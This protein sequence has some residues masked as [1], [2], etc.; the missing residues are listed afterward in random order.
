MARV[1]VLDGHSAAALAFTR[2]LGKRGH[3]VAVGYAGGIFAAAMRS[4]YCREVFEY[5]DSTK[6]VTGFVRAILEF[7][8]SRNIELLIPITDWTTTPVS[9]QRDEIERYCRIA[10]PCP[11][12]LEL[13]SDKYR[14]IELAASFEVPVPETWLIRRAED[15]DELP[16]LPYPVVVKDRESARWI[17]NGAVFGSVSYAYSREDLGL[18][19]E[20]RLAAAG[21]VL[22]QRFA[23]GKGIGFSCFAHA[24]EIYL[25]FQ[26][27]RLRETDPRGSASS[28]RRSVPVDAQVLEFSRRLMR[29]AGFEGLA[30]VEFKQDRDQ[31]TLMEINGRPWGSIQLPIS[32]GIDYPNY[33]VDWYLA[34]RLPPAA[35][36]YRKIVCRRLVG[37]LNHLDSLRRGKPPEWPTPYPNFW[38]SL[39]K[40]AVPWYPGVRYDDLWLSDPR[41]GLAGLAHWFGVRLNRRGKRKAPSSSGK[42]KRRGIVHCHTTYSYD[43]KLELAEL[44]DLLRREG[45][46]FVALTEHTQGLTAERYRELVDHCRAESDGRFLA[47]PGIEFRSDGMEIAGIGL[48]EWIEESEPK[49]TAAAIASAGG[50]SIW[51]HPFKDGAWSGAFPDCDAVELLNGKVNGTLAPDFRL[52]KAYC[53]QRRQGRSFHAIF[54]LDFHNLR[55]PRQVW[56]ECE[57]EELSQPALLEALREGKFV[58][59]VAH[60]SMTSSGE[61]HKLD[62]CKM[63]ILRWAFLA[64]AAILR[65]TPTGLR[66][67]LLSLSRPLVRILKRNH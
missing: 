41:P 46:D 16:E 60:G 45:F 26:W 42:R 27:V 67:S 17:G 58:S 65:S 1:L 50:F 30:M 32:S 51:V 25:P 24:G 18:K 63:L 62:Y 5:P 14:T 38:T 34:Q 33:A 55:Q 48:P 52:R 21:D 10:L 59:R 35:V 4:R 22:V 39:I 6:D 29:G 15:L 20:R 3:W 11:P 2:S 31:L 53:E 7:V 64:W 12:A 57:V 19:V 43:G 36:D 44:C 28:A 49:A 54:G 8:Q 47:I 13:A 66:N 40:I 56:I 9:R 23:G 37:E 61:I